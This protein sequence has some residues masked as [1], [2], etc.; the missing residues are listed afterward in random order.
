LARCSA[1]GPREEH[2]VTVAVDVLDPPL[3]R[4]GVQVVEYLDV[5][6][7]IYRQSLDHLDGFGGI[8]R[9]GF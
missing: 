3:L 6:R 4:P 1:C 5:W 2:Y 9:K 7:S 8:E